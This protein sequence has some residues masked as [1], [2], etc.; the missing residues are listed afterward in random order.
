MAIEIKSSSHEIEILLSNC[1]N[2]VFNKIGENII[3]DIPIVLCDLEYITTLFPSNSN[4]NDY[5]FYKRILK[6]SFGITQPKTFSD[7]RRKHLI[8]INIQNIKTLSLNDTELEAIIAH[9]LGHILNVPKEGLVDRSQSEFYADHFAKS[10]GLK[11]DLL[12]SIEKYLSQNNADNINLFQL[13]IAKLNSDEIF[14]GE[15]KTL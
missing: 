7:G 11:D 5:E 6:N 4:P 9:E 12:S 3:K 15:I 1:I 8:L 14:S 10:L 2:R 13:R